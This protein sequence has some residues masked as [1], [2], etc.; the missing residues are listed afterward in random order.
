[1]RESITEQ[2]STKIYA[3]NP[4]GGA[5]RGSQHLQNHPYA[6]KCTFLE[7]ASWNLAHKRLKDLR[8]VCPRALVSGV[9][10][11]QPLRVLKSSLGH[12]IHIFRDGKLK[13]GVQAVQCLKNRM[14]ER[15][16]T[17]GALGPPRGS[18]APRVSGVPRVSGPPGALGPLKGRG[19]ETTMKSTF[20]EMVIWNLGCKQLNDLRVV[21][22]RDPITW[23]L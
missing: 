18:G 21:N 16:H 3:R 8:I 5:P 7:I 23:R 15:F 4:L 13:F 11:G 1:M 17:L 12:K 9:P 19:T 2:P 22:C 10:Q 14:P 6:I 20:L